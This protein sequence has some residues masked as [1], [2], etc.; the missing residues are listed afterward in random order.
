MSAT[1]IPPFSNMTPNTKILSGSTGAKLYKN[2]TDKKWVIKQSLKGPGGFEQVKTESIVDDIYQALGIPVPKHILDV[3]N[4]ALILEYIDGKS[5]ADATPAE[6]TKAKEELQ[7]GFIVDAL[8]ANWDVIGM[9][10]DNILL[11]SDGSPAVRI[12][13]GGSLTFRA[14]GGKKPFNNVVTEVDTMR[15]KTISPQAAKIF[16]DLT[17]TDIDTQIKTII[18]PNYDLILSLTPEDLKPAMK[19]RIDNLIERTVWT[20]ASAFKN[21]VEETSEP[22]FIPAVQAALIKYFKPGWQNNFKNVNVGPAN[23][24]E[25]R[26]LAFINKTLKDNGAI[27]SG[28]FILKA[29]GSFVDEKSVD[30]DIYVPTAHAEE[31]RKVMTKLFDSTSVVKHVVSDSP[32]SFFKKNGIVSVSKYSKQLPK[33]AEMDIVEIAADRTP[34][35]VVKNFDLTF[36]ENWYDGDNVWMAYPDHVKS[37]S[38]F[39]ENH[40]LDILFTGNPVLINRMKKYIDRGFKISINNP[41]TKKAENVSNGISKGTLF[42]QQIQNL[43]KAVP[44]DTHFGSYGVYGSY[45]IPA[46]N[47]LTNVGAPGGVSA[48][49]LSALTNTIIQPVKNSSIDMPITNNYPNA[50]QT[51][52]SSNFTRLTPVEIQAIRHYTGSGYVNVNRFLYSD[53][54]CNP[55]DNLVYNAIRIKFPRNNGETTVEYNKRITYYYF[56]NLFNAIQKVPS[57]TDKPIKLYRGTEKW[58]LEK[59]IDKFYYINSFSSTSVTSSVAKGFGLTYNFTTGTYGL[60]KMYVFYVHPRCNY[61]NVK[62]ISLHKGEDE[63]LLN[64]YNRY[65]YIDET[66]STE[67]KV[68]YRNYAVFPIDIDIP[69]TY[70]TFMPWKKSIVDMTTIVANGV[71]VPP[72]PP[73]PEPVIPEPVLEESPS[74]QEEVKAEENGKKNNNRNN[75]KTERNVSG[76]NTTREGTLEGGRINVL[77][78]NELGT[79]NYNQSVVKKQAKEKARFNKA[80]TNKKLK[81]LEAKGKRRTFPRMTVKMKQASTNYKK[82]AYDENTIRR[83]TEPLPSFPGKAPTAA[84]MEVVKKMVAFFRNTK[85]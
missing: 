11:P 12:D 5:L 64:P 53:L 84:E 16:G 22:T 14:Q 79:I 59:N 65:L 26:L 39:L 42:Q 67:D 3:P 36:C 56:V 71:A 1:N 2:T 68:T 23:N 49:A 66:T 4:K 17:D 46:V 80:I 50:F 70:S 37:K 18:V 15:N 74:S 62:S 45:G 77:Y 82:P 29:I 44:K 83:F 13:N 61:M 34:V 69:T 30:M 19:G 41:V 40:Y 81:P 6:R 31:F 20:N 57:I 55:A 47:A 43:S 85:K 60:K 52:F 72:P 8:L 24:S 25:Q 54:P 48:A 51:D 7:K 78:P 32:G 9:L 63:I 27:I 75:N 10:E 28:G 33:Y 21:D 73:P 35:E 76:V 58:Y 38:G